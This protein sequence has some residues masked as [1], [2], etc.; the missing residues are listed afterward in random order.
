MQP[1]VPLDCND[2]LT[3]GM[4]NM[5]KTSVFDMFQSDQSWSG[6]RRLTFD[7]FGQFADVNVIGRFVEAC[8]AAHRQA[9]LR[10]TESQFDTLS[11]V[12]QPGWLADLKAAQSRSD[13]G[14]VR[15]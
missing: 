11:A 15:R 10:M 4:G 3:T 14:P 12:D 1:I 6:T 9:A 7:I 13:K 2:F 8:R 5:A